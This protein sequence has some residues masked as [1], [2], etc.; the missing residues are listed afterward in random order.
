MVVGSFGEGPAE[1]NVLMISSQKVEQSSSE[2]NYVALYSTNP[3]GNVKF[4]PRND[5][6]C[7]YCGKCGHKE[8]M[9]WKKHGMPNHI[10]KKWSTNIAQSD[11]GPSRSRSPS[12]SA[13]GSQ[14]VP[15]GMPQIS[16][17]QFN[18]ML[19]CF[20]YSSKL[21]SQPNIK[22]NMTSMTFCGSIP[23]KYCDYWVI[24]NG[25]TNHM[26]CRLDWMNNVRKNHTNNRLVHLP[27]GQ[28]SSVTHC[29]YCIIGGS[30]LLSDVLF[31][32]SFRYI[33]ISTSQLTR[34]LGLC[35]VFFHDFVAFQD[36][37]NGR[38]TGTGLHLNE[39]YY[40][41]VKRK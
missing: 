3:G 34:D 38:I 17:D 30:F 2:S 15:Q 20:T 14:A 28:C 40:L 32:P 36:P 41:Y 39:L 8:D 7:N 33:L 25:A 35:A 27:N 4:K 11:S 16:V 10:K 9:C 6:A 23:I 29:G 31:V 22:E 13:A 12:K 24:D 37:S 5:F 18:R 1:R 19:Q 21:D 26:T